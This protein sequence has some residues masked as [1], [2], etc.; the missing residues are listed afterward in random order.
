MRRRDL[1]IAAAAAVALRSSAGRAQQP[2][3][4]LIGFVHGS[5]PVGQYKSYIASFF[6]GLQEEGFEPGRNVAVEYR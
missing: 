3:V 6:A 2:K 4:P 1:V 5:A